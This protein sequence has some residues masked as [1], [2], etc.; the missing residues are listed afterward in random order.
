MQIRILDMEKGEFVFCN[1]RQKAVVCIATRQGTPDPTSV[2]VE[3]GLLVRN[4]K[5]T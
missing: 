4:V 3:I 5:S 1:H 2:Q